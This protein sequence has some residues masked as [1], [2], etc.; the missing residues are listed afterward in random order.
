MLRAQAPE[1]PLHH[2]VSHAAIDFP[3]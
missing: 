2:Q 3:W 1:L